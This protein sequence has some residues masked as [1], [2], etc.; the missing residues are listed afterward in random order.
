MLVFCNDLVL[1]VVLGADSQ[2]EQGTDPT[3]VGD[4]VIGI[5]VDTYVVAIPCDM[6]CWVSPDSTAH[7]ALIALWAATGLQ[8]DKEGWCCF[9]CAGL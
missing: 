4:E 7:V 8:W 9:K 2:D 3:C 1:A 5:R 6:R